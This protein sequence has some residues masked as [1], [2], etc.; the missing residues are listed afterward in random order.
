MIVYIGC[1]TNSANTNGLHVVRVDEV[2][3]A[4]TRLA[5]LPEDNP[6]Y[7][8][9]AD[10]ILYATS[11]GGLKSF[12]LAGETLTPIDVVA[13]GGQAMCH[14]AVQ[15]DG[16]HVTWAAYSNGR[17]GRVEV[18]D[19]RFG[20]VTTYRHAGKGP[21][22]PRQEA[23]HPHCAVPTPDGKGFVVCD[24]GLDTIM[25]YPE[26]EPFLTTPAG[27]GPR[28]VLF[29]PD[30]RLAFVVF[31]LENLLGVY[32]WTAEKGFGRLLD[33]VRTVEA[34][35]T[36][37]GPNGDLGAAVR[38]TPDARRIV[39][40][41]RGEQSLVTYDFD[42]ETGRLS[43]VARSRLPG[44]WPRDFRF[45]TDTLALV[46]MERTDEVHTLRYDP[47]TGA[48]SVCATLGGFHRP[49]CVEKK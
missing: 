14:V 42:A 39:V 11:G 27:A 41:N 49:V 20:A 34:W 3:G 12:R 43:L 45:L 30:G 6:L 17:A 16:R 15:P 22:L 18:S 8:A 19:G 29:S 25:R 5:A 37:R 2:T 31:E 23:A 48:F 47:A 38:L 26:G 40:S 21:N 24:L 33:Q 36:G 35:P 32:A 44:S 10:D 28:H 4:L 46:T 9:K 1:Y 13:L 7:L